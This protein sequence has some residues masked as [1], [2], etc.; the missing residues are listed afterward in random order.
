MI[1]PWLDQWDSQLVCR[2]QIAA[3]RCERADS[4]GKLPNRGRGACIVQRPRARGAFAQ[5]ARCGKSHRRGAELPAARLHGDDRLEARTPVL[6]LKLLHVMSAIA[7]LGNI[8]TGLF[9]KA[10][11]DRTRD[12]QVIAHT[13]EGIIRADRWFT[14]PGV[15]GLVLFGAGAAMAE[16]LPMLRTGWILWAIVLFIVSGAAFIAQVV[17]LQRRM[18]VVAGGAAGATMDWKA[19]HALSRRWDLWGGV[20]L[21]APL[22]ALVLMVLKPRLPAL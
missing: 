1:G 4:R 5:E 8:T 9:W 15:I 11:A 13:L 3:D 20:A 2:L 12:P 17:P 22:G 10:W 19:Y 16:R 18:A 14:I 21:L 6:I 7:F